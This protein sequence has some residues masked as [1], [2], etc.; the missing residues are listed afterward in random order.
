MIASTGEGGEMDGYPVGLTFDIQQREDGSLVATC[1]AIQLRVRARDRD[2]LTVQLSDSVR[3][4]AR[5]LERLG[6]E[7]LPKFL[8]ARGIG[9][10]DASM[11][12]ARITFPLLL[13]PDPTMKNIPMPPDKEAARAWIAGN[14]ELAARVAKA[15][16]ELDAGLGTRWVRG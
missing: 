9:P 8:E 11:E 15:R 5:S 1:D 16:A 14:K 3:R 2:E 4:T 13:L 12:E 6:K 10:K 7:T